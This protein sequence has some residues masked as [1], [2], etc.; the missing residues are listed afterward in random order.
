MLWS[1]GLSEVIVANTIPL[2]PEVAENTTKIKALSVGGLIAE[3]TTT[4]TVTIA[5]L[6]S[7]Y[8]HAPIISLV[9][10]GYAWV[11][12][13]TVLVSLITA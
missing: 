11:R 12:G 13:T 9:L 6:Y 3:V 10:C 8:S 1:Q 2:R 7:P 4:S 5:C